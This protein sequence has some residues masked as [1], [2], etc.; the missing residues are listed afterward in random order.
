MKVFV[1]ACGLMVAM[2][3]HAP[4]WGAGSADIGRS[5][6]QPGVAPGFGLCLQCHFDGPTAPRFVPARFNADYLASVFAQV[7]Q[8]NANL[9][10][11]GTV[12]MRD[13]ATYLGLAGRGQANVT[14]ADRLLDWGE[15]SFPQQLSPRRQVTGELLGYIYRF[16][17]DTGLY[18]GIKDGQV[19]VYDSRT[20]GSTIQTLGTVRSFLDQMPEGR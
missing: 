11:L 18:V 20:P 15:D 7:E 1:G 8:M 13:V 16:Y 17:P 2:V 3:L 12:G 5:Y 4:A 9:G 19:H 14:D 10:I 6:F